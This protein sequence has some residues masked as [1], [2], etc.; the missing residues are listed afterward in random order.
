[1][2]IAQFPNSSASRYWRLEDPG[3]YLGK[4][5][6]EVVVFEQPPT[7][8]IC[9]YFDIF[10][11]QGMVDKDGIAL[12][13]EYQQEKG[14]K[15]VV[16]QDDDLKVEASNPHAKDHEV[17]D[18]VSVV[19]K[20]IEIADLVTTTN[21]YL[22]KKLVK[23]N[24]NVFV[25]P[26]YMDMERWDL[27]NKQHRGGQIRIF[28]SGSI[29]HL[30]DLQS[31]LPVL[32]K[33][34]K[35]FHQV[36]YILMGEPRIRQYLNG[37]RAEVMLGVPFDAY[38]TKLHSIGADIAIAPL[39]KS[40]FNHCKSPIKFMEYAICKYPGIYSDVV[41]PDH[42]LD[43]SCGTIAGNDEQWFLGIRNY[44]ICPALRMDIAER[45]YSYTKSWYSLET[46]T[47]L[48]EKAYKNLF[49]PN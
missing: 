5:G 12:L 44:I 30:I 4:L 35:Q 16:D 10:V 9:E 42:A 49:K 11:T 6:H 26:N 31:V 47:K 48:L 25:F 29:T 21:D 43:G 38:P 20:T 33:V 37:L 23:L 41:Y 46:R 15:I 40:E 3:K 18:A 19:K 13:Y 39:I 8:E 22:R 17:T 14:K 36:I 27:P 2:K 7:R 1:M 45:A 28:W 24:P 34:Q 32:H